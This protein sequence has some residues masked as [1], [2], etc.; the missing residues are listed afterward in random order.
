MVTET[1][2]QVIIKEAEI[3]NKECMLIL[4]NDDVNTF[5]FVIEALVKVCN[6][7]SEQAEQCAFLVHYK[8]KCAIK[9]GSFYK[10]VPLK[11]ALQELGLT[12]EI[13]K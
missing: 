13:A 6:H 4:W 1:E 2:K 11:D 5:D 7:T 10:L 8:G 12:V 3:V 9:N